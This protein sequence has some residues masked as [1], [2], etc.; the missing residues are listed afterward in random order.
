MLEKDSFVVVEQQ[1][2]Q[3]LVRITS[4]SKS[5]DTFRGMIENGKDEGADI[6]ADVEDVKAYLGPHPDLG[7]VF[8]T[9]TVR[10][11]RV[12]DNPVFGTIS[13][14][15]ETD[16][17]LRNQLLKEVKV[18]YK[19]LKSKGLAYMCD[20]F[21]L[22]FERLTR[23]PTAKTMVGWYKTNRNK[24]TPDRPDTIT[25]KWHPSLPEG[26][27]TDIFYHETG[28]GFWYRAFTDALRAKW[29]LQYVKCSKLEDTYSEE[30]ILAACKAAWGND[31]VAKDE[32]DDS[33]L[34]HVLGNLS[35]LYGLRGQDVRLL[36][37]TN[38]GKLRGLI[39]SVAQ[40]AGFECSRETHITDYAGRSVEEYFSEAWRVFLSGKALPDSL[41]D[42]ME[43]TYEHLK[44]QRLNI[45]SHDAD[46]DDD[47]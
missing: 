47:D 13:W 1:A 19:T 35:F 11:V 45:G 21:S 39:Q 17:E 2:R 37:T 25:L 8:S 22:N 18:A 40:F 15:W 32:R 24:D 41:E 27:L 5:G 38:P 10:L 26:T 7:R 46:S 3:F 6:E 29:T 36:Y 44:G 43:E 16:E 20:A 33:I 34:A 42:L 12:D 23:M 14:Y 31:L 30:D 28:H 4:V 9:S